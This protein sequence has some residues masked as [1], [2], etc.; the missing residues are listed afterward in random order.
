[1]VDLEAAIREEA[2]KYY[3]GRKQTATAIRDIV[4][5]GKERYLSE[6]ILANNI[7]RIGEITRACA[8][9]YKILSLLRKKYC[10][11]D[12]RKAQAMIGYLYNILQAR[13]ADIESKAGQETKFMSPEIED[14]IRIIEESA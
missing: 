10:E 8:N 5:A 3:L 13:K 6:E 9:P 14:F 11:M 4:A 2:D 7:Q 1:M 12:S